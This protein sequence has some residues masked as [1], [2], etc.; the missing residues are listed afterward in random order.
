MDFKTKSKEKLIGEGF[1]NPMYIPD[2]KLLL[3]FNENRQSD[4]NTWNKDIYILNVSTKAK[5]KAATG[6]NYLWV[7]MK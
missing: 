2:N 3:L 6:E 7:P 4:D 1:F 5:T